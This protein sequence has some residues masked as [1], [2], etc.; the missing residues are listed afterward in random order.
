MADLAQQGRFA[1]GRFGV[2]RPMWNLGVSIKVLVALSRNK[3]VPGWVGHAAVCVLNQV[4][5]HCPHRL[6]IC[7]RARARVKGSCLL[8]SASTMASFNLDTRSAPKTLRTAIRR[9][10]NMPAEIKKEI[11]LEIAHVLFTDIVG[12]SSCLLTS[13]AR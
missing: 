6:R 11:Q 8:S 1:F 2:I 5:M 4:G 10:E 12:Y 3:L 13:N 9:L 7:L